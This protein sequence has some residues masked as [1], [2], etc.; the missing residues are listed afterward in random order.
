MDSSEASQSELL[1][2]VAEGIRYKGTGR[3][4][5]K[6]SVKERPKKR[7]QK[8]KLRVY[9]DIRTMTAGNASGMKSDNMS[10]G[11]KQLKTG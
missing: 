9:G 8:P 3:S 1:V 7:Y 5:L 4:V 11:P 2:A 6:A 10:V